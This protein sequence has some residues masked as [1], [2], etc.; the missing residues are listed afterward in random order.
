MQATGENACTP[1]VDDLLQCCQWIPNTIECTVEGDMHPGG[2]L[3][4][5]P[6]S[7]DVDLAVL[8][9]HSNHHTIATQVPTLLN[10]G[11]H[12]VEFH[13]RIEKVATARTDDREQLNRRMFSCQ[14]N[15]PVG[16]RCPTFVGIRTQFDAIGA[17]SLRCH[18]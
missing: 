11:D 10:I 14:G 15:H 13:C 16:R 1:Q 18:T 4:Q 6:A 2:A 5:F 9:E 17:L 3:D 8:S 7:I 12:G